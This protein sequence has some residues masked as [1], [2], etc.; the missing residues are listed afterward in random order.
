MRLLQYHDFVKGASASRTEGMAGDVRFC[1]WFGTRRNKSTKGLQRLP[2][3]RVVHRP[4]VL[5]N[6]RRDSLG[7]RRDSTTCIEIHSLKQSK[8]LLLLLETFRQHHTVRR[9]LMPRDFNCGVGSS[10]N[11]RNSTPPKQSTFTKENSNGDFDLNAR[12][13]Q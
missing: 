11:L 8:S 10:L 5:S 9:D 1:R 12:R 7:T 2:K 3:S 13:G 6:L 4:I